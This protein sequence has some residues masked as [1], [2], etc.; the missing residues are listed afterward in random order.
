[1][2]N[3]ATL[4]VRVFDEF[5]GKLLTGNLGQITRDGKKDH[6][7]SK[8]MYTDYK[9]FNGVELDNFRRLSR[10]TLIRQNLH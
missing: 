8:R 2:P 7:E 5:C 6:A 10:T 1:M 9:G 4:V 3:P